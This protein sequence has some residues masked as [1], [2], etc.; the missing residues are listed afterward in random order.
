MLRNLNV[1]I[2][3]ADISFGTLVTSEGWR[4]KP[5]KRERVFAKRKA[6]PKVPAKMEQ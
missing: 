2:P 4:S 5:A 6:A 3:L 1:F